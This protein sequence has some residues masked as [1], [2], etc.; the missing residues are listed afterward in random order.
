MHLLGQAIRSRGFKAE[1]ISFVELTAQ[2]LGLHVPPAL[3]IFSETES[4]FCLSNEAQ[5]A[6]ATTKKKIS[7]G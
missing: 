3:D 7:N 6:R 4:R 5:R 2:T 1:N